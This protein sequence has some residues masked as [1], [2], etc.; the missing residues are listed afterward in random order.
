MAVAHGRGL[1]SE[2]CRARM[3][4][5]HVREAEAE[6]G[7]IVGTVKDD[8]LIRAYL[9]GA[10]DGLTYNIIASK[11]WRLVAR[12]AICRGRIAMLSGKTTV[13]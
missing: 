9:D 5:R 3:S 1:T 7:R 6:H 8:A 10:P 13:S 12:A 4:W 2:R 11:L